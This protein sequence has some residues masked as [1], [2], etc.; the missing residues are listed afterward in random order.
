[1]Q[2]AKGALFKSTQEH[3]AQVVR[4]RVVDVG[5]DH[6]QVRQLVLQ[7]LVA[8]RMMQPL[9]AIDSISRSFMPSPKAMHS[10]SV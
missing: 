3:L 6:F 5:A 2:G 8:S 10:F 1:M 9:P 4:H 7:A